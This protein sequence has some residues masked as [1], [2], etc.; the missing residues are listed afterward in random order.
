M[1]KLKNAQELVKRK[2]P[3]ANKTMGLVMTLTLLSCDVIIDAY[4]LYENKIKLLTHQRLKTR[5]NIF[6]IGNL[7]PKQ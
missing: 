4:R 2:Q 1:G 3:F 7:P 6:T 5:R